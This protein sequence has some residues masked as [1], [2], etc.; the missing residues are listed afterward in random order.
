MIISQVYI[1][2]T[3]EQHFGDN[4]RHKWNLLKYNNI[5]E[6]AIF[7]GL[8]TDID[9]Q[10]LLNH[11]GISIIIWGGGDMKNDNLM[12]VKELILKNKAYTFVYPGTLSDD[13]KKL[14]IPHKSFYFAV[15]DYNNFKPNILGDKIYVYRGINGNRSKYFQWDSDIIP[16]IDFF[17]TNN[18][19]YTDKID[20][21]NLKKNYYDKSFVFIK[22]NIKGGCTTMFEMGCMGRKT[23][24]RGKFDLLNFKTYNNTQEVI[25]IIEQ[26]SKYVGK[27]REDVSSYTHSI[28]SN[29]D[30]LRL[31]FWT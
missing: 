7:F 10:K 13:L 28:L 17:G 20:I 19:I 14:S 11:K 25:K 22:P 16:I 18:V 15:K 23:I 12:I 4:F 8:Y 1:S 3:L 24:G 26:E 29:D 2:S 27:I 5:N 9:I 6:P 31:D 30:W 21:T